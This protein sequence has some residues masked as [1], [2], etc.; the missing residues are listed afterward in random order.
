MHLK[1]PHNNKINI[2]PVKAFKD[3][4][5]W[6]IQ[7]KNYAVIVDPG[8]AKPSLKKLKE[9]NLELAGILITHKHFDHIGGVEELIK[10]FPNIKIFGPENNEFQFKYQVVKEGD[11]IS[12]SNTK[13]KFYIIE[14]PGHTLDHIVYVDSE[15]LFC[16]DTLFACGCGRLFEGTYDEMFHSL[17]KISSLKP[18]TKVYCAHEY[19]KE[20]IK[21]AL[22]I[23]SKNEEL[24]K[25]SKKL[26]NVEITI[27]SLLMDELKT[28]PFLR[29]KTSEEFKSIR[30]RKDEF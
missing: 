10:N 15:H 28:N 18:N 23:D 20:N 8:E 16:G 30:K 4:Y 7:E 14:T 17:S 21:F 24:N 11:L 1:L 2:F 5:I 6:I 29:A 9:M 22:T 12:I 25:R 19:T 13:I 27:P 26:Q 3:N